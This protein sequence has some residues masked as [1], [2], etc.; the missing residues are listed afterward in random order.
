MSDDA[1]EQVLASQ[2]TFYDLRAPDFAN[3]SS[4]SDRRHRGNPTSALVAEWVAEVR[5][6]GDV[7]E[8]ACGSGSF[9]GDLARRARSLTCVDGSP[10]ML[11][12]NRAAVNDPR[13][14]YECADLFAWTTTEQFDLVFFG[15]WLS[16]V[17]PTHFDRFWSLVRACLRPGGRAAFVDEDDRATG[18]EAFLVDDGIPIARR[19]LRDGREF[20]I[21]KVFWEPA[22]LTA[23]LDQA[24]WDATV[25]PVGD[26]FL[27][28]EARPR[29]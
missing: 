22:D 2:R 1:V 18:N 26:T 4:P 8:L 15:F 14:R 7:L 28:G 25:R 20:D 29:P 6:D 16:H 19:R 24:G 9:T 21:V 23:R 3:A 10:R 27:I 11:G 12:L 17:P 13:V 5:P